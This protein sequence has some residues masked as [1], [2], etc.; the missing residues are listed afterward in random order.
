M[1]AN[2][3]RRLGVLAGDHLKAS[4]DL[5]IPLMGMACFIKKDIPAVFKLRWMAA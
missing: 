3:F 4:S 1:S 2:I 5:G